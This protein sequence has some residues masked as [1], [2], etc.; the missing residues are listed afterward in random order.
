VRAIAGLVVASAIAVAARRK[1]ALSPGGAATAVV[2]ATICTEA[3]WS[4]GIL[5]IAFFVSGTALSMRGERVKRLRTES[6]VAK[7]GERDGWQVLANGGVF[8]SAALASIMFPAEWWMVFGAGAIAAATADTWS[9]EIGTL[10]SGLPV[11]IVSWKRV[12]TGTSGG[13]TPLGGT[14]ALAGAL[15]IAGGVLLVGWHPN[16]ALAAVAGGF[17]GALVDSI[18]GATLQARRWCDA[19]DCGTERAIH[20]C[21]SV[22]R[23]SGGI[24][25]MDNDVVNALSTLCGGII[26]L[27]LFR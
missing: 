16:A 4:W 3:G 23:K 18:A 26:G 17:S 19:C 6:V 8:A 2:V 5:L 20:T 22:T 9:T 13:I 27:L 7:G 1:K 14:A 12:P 24:A 10:S 11:S 25:W 21:G 15:F